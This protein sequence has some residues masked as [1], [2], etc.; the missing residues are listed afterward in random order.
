MNNDSGNNTTESPEANLGQKLKK[1]SDS[2]RKFAKTGLIA[3]V[4]LS[5]ANRPAWGASFRCTVSGFDSLATIGSGPALTDIEDMCDYMSVDDVFD[6]QHVDPNELVT[7]IFP[8]CS[9]LVTPTDLTVGESLQGLNGADQIT[10]RMVAAHFN[11]VVNGTNPFGNASVEVI[12]CHILTNG[13]YIPYSFGGV[14][15][16]GMEIFNFLGY[17]GIK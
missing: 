3:P 17:I 5:L 12:Y 16:N 9:G 1:I 6:S 8:S 2:R 14:I 15:L 7:A 4:I 10:E 11:D 13:P